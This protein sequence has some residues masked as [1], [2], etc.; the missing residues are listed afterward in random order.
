MQ[1]KARLEKEAKL[2]AAREA[3]AK[4]SAWLNNR[5]E[6]LNDLGSNITDQQPPEPHCK[7]RGGLREADEQGNWVTSSSIGQG[8]SARTAA[9]NQRIEKLKELY[10]DEWGKKGKA[11]FIAHREAI[12]VK[13]KNADRKLKEKADQ[14]SKEERPITARTIQKY[15]KET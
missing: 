2:K 4:D 1:T 15:F 10:P 12:R 7:L 13:K 9:R 3:S 5:P 6:R 14:E 11:A 8:G